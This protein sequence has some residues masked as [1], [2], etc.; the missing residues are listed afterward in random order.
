MKQ[1]L[2]EPLL[3][4]IGLGLL[5]FIVYGLVAKDETDENTIVF[6]SYDL[7]SLLSKWELQWKRPPTEEELKGILETNIKQEL[8]YQEAL[9]MNLDHNDEIIKRRLSQKMEF[10][11]N[12]LVSMQPPTDE[13]LTAYYSLK[14]NNY[15]TN[16]KYTLHYV[17]YSFDKNKQPFQVA[18]KALSQAN[19]DQ[20]AS[21]RGAGDPLPFPNYFENSDE[22]SIRKTLGSSF[23]D[24]LRV[25]DTNVW[26]GPIQ[27]GFGFHLVYITDRKQ[28]APIPLEQIKERVLNDYNY[29]RQLKLDSALYNEIKK[30]YS[31]EL[32][33]NEE[34]F[35]PE[36]I[37]LVE[38]TLKG[39]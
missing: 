18:S 27:S 17:N 23:T 3:H 10:L 36:I 29:D 30:Q 15:L 31:F 9:K 21:L 20:L 5:I 16:Y 11:S 34:E 2:K 24:T 39:T 4:F 19:K 37:E 32:D 6:D 28:P 35:D 38:S 22:L 7:N 33:L 1:L 13:E 26:T 12:D 25:I 8:F 14:M